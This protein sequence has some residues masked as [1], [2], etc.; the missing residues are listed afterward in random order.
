MSPERVF[1][2]EEEKVVP[3]TKTED[4]NDNNN[5]NKMSNF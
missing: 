1:V 5:N 3:C 2:S 4:R